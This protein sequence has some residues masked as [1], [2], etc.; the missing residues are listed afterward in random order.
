MVSYLSVA[1]NILAPNAKAAK[2][3][4]P[5]VAVGRALNEVSP[6]HAQ[7]EI[8]L[9]KQPEDRTSGPGWDRTSD[10]TIMSRL[11]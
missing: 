3:N 2:V 5:E 11:L 10:Q 1:I 4:I 8:Y 6:D 9:D 7:T